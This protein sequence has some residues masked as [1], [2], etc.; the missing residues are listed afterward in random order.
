[1]HYQAYG[2]LCII[3]G[4]VYLIKPNIFRVGIWKKTAVTQQVFNPR[5][6]N[7][8]MRILGGIFILA[9]IY[10]LFFK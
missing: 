5:Q 6:Y 2:V 3:F 10:F 9:G 1:M 8:Y 7:I 4:I